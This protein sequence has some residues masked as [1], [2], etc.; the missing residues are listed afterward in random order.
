MTQLESG[1]SRQE[2]FTSSVSGFM[3]GLK[4]KEETWK[5][6]RVQVWDSTFE[7]GEKE[8]GETERQT[9]GQ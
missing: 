8:E 3:K 4:G 5:T 7:G 6:Y 1:D 9:T 2:G